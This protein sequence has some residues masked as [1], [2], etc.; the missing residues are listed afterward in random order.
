MSVEDLRSAL[1][2]Q[3]C[4]ALKMMYLKGLVTP[5][6]GNISVRV[7]DTIL[8]TPSSWGPIARLKYE[9]N[10]DDIVVVDLGGR[11]IRGGKPSSELPMHLEIYRSCQNCNA[12]VHIHGV[13]APM[14]EPGEDLYLDVELKYAKTRICFVDEYTPGSVELAKAVA[15]KAAEGCQIIYLK[16]HGIVATASNLAMALELAEAAEI[17]ATRTFISRI[18]RYLERGKQA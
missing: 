16:N 1:A 14:L 17:I 12:V 15:R 2:K 6:T 7:G 8:R 9:L 10:P 4:E 11:V 13:F 3:M 5:L 18:L